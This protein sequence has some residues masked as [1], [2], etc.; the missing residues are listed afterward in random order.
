MDYKNI[1]SSNNIH[2]NQSVIIN[3]NKND[4]QIFFLI[5]HTVYDGLKSYNNIIIPCL[6]GIILKF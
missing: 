4:K 3:Y 1:I 5:N 6:G 2:N